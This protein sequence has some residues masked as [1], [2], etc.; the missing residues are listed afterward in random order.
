MIEQP[1]DA[2]GKA[3]V[4]LP[5]LDDVQD[6]HLSYQFVARFNADLADAAYKP[7]QSPQFEQYCLCRQDPPLGKGK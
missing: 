6:R 4:A 5:E 1:T 3:R 2:A 7:A